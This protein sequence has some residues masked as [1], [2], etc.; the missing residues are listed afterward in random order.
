MR[1]DGQRRQ[2]FPPIDAVWIMGHAP[3]PGG[4]QK[5]HLAT[6]ANNIALDQIIMDAAL[7]SIEQLAAAAGEE[8]QR[9]LRDS[10]NKLVLSLERPSDTIHRYGHMV[11]P[12]VWLPPKLL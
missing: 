3:R 5:G 1:R 7:E 6:V 10:L 2:D 11:S 8:T 4:I 9:K 12:Y